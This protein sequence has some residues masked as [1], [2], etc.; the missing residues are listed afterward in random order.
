MDASVLQVSGEQVVSGRQTGWSAWT[1][2][3]TRTRKA[4]ATA[5]LANVAEALKALLDDLISHGVI[6]P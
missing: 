4:T 1:G 3:P 5:T 6:G 2:T